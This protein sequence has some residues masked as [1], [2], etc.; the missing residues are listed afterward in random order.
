VL[1]ARLVSSFEV[2]LSVISSSGPNKYYAY[3]LGGVI[4][5]INN[6]LII[7]KNILNNEIRILSIVKFVFFL[8]IRETGRKFSFLGK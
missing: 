5:S 3:Y 7:D 8:N 4:V 6:K 1:S 2:F